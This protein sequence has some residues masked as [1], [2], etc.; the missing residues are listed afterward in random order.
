M[1]ISAR[2]L[3][4]ALIT[5]FLLAVVPAGAS[6]ITSLPGGSVIPMPAVGYFGPG[7]EVF[8]PEITWTSTN[9]SNQGGSVFGYT[10][11]YGFDVNG[12]WDGS[13][14]PMAGVNDSYDSWD[15]TDT[16]T[17]AFA[18]P[19]SAVGGFIDYVPGSTPTTIAVYDTGKNLIESYNL[20]FTTGGGTNTGQFLG[21]QESG[22]TIASFTLTDN[23]VGLTDLTI[24]PTPEPGT[25]LPAAAG[26]LA[27]A[28][29]IR[30]KIRA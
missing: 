30:R 14:G 17:F 1:G 19:V 29:L 25:F 20:T 22:P 11:G 21:F 10:G 6:V 9:A 12:Y 3:V 8:G 13:L 5:A 27:V 24:L 26:L 16:M 4:T 15:V 7:P 23:Y 18:T 2:K 28:G